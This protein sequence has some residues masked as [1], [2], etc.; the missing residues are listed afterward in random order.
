MFDINLIQNFRKNMKRALGLSS[1]VQ[2][3]FKEIKYGRQTH[4]IQKT[5][6]NSFPCALGSDELKQQHFSV[7]KNM[8]LPTCVYR[9]ETL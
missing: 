6:H 3:M 4:N 8:S 5:N 1:E 7:E 2:K 9:C